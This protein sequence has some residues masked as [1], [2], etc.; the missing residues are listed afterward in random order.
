MPELREELVQKLKALTEA[1]WAG[2]VDWPMVVRWLDNFAVDTSDTLSERLHALFLLSQFTYFGSREM[3]ELLKSLYRDLYRYPVVEHLRRTNGDTL[4][5]ALLEGLF[6]GE[7][8]RTR[9]LGVGNPSESGTHLLYYFRQENSLSSNLFVN[10]HEVF[11]ASGVA[12]PELAEPQ[13]RRYVFIDDFCGSGTQAI[14]YS[15]SIVANLK[16]ANPTA[17]VVYYALFGMTEGLEKARSE[18]AFDEVNSVFELDATFK[19]FG[20]SSRY[21]KGTSSEIDKPFSEQMCRTY[22]DKLFPGSPLGYKDGQL[23]M[24]FFHNVPDNTLPIIWRTPTDAAP[25]V[26]VFRRYPKLYQWGG[27]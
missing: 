20:G 6:A 3:R 15:Q 23:L 1:V 5:C 11:T 18:T 25:W 12:T 17:R 22:G 21:F 16:L 19:C 9:F 7:L 26:P 10:T 27:I 8:A 2:V 4:N 24:G 14:A 13:V